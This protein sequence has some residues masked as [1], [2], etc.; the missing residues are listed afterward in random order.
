M[1]FNPRAH[2]TYAINRLLE[3][4]NC[5]LFMGM[6]TGKSAVTLT[7]IDQLMYDN[8]EVNKVLIIAPKRV[9]ENTWPDEISKWD[10]VKHLK[11]SL[12]LGSEKQR[13][14]ALRQKADIYITNPENVAWLVAQYGTAFPFDMWVVDESS[15]FKSHKSQR[16]KALMQVCPKVKRILLLS[17]TPMAN[18]ELDLWSQIYLLDRGDRLEKTITA[19][20]TKYFTYDPYGMKYTPHSPERI[21]DKIGDICFSMKTEDYIDLPELIEENVN[22]RLPDEIMQQYHEFEKRMVLALNDADHITAVSAAGLSNKL[23]Q[24]A[25]G[26]VYNEAKEYFEV[27]NAKLEAL[28]EDL[29]VLNGKPMLLAYSYR[30]DVER[31]K[32]YLKQYQPREMQTTGDKDDWNK[33]KIPLMLIHPASGGY[34]LNLQH[35]GNYLGFFGADWNLEHRQQFI[36]RIHRDGQKEKHVFLRNYIVPGTIEDRV[37]QALAEKANGQEA[38][39]DAVKAIIDKYR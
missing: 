8:L 15:K 28:A 1:I 21:F 38:M 29:E 31:I 32:Q 35:G 24:F 36:K 18:S 5:A 37:M 16:F 22:V 34:G 27:H 19:Y 23:R 10:H 2:Q 9:A 30:S 17:G 4:N 25:N 39:L 7:G 14:A 33:G 20:K 11:Y 13:K 26:A 12:V 3:T 6:G